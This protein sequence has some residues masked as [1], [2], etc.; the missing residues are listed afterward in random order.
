MIPIFRTWGAFSM[1]CFWLPLGRTEEKHRCQRDA[2]GTRRPF[3]VSLPAM[4]T[5]VIS[6][7]WLSSTFG[8]VVLTG[9]VDPDY[10]YK[11]ETIRPNLRLRK[12]TQVVGVITDV[13]GARF[14]Y[15]RVELREYVSQ[16]KQPTI[17]TVVT[18]ANGQFDL[19]LVKSGKYRLLPSPTR[20]FKQPEKLEC[21]SGDTCQLKI[22]LQANATDQPES[23]C[24]IR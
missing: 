22:A 24:P 21:Q 16:R 2:Q 20:A 8:Q 13:A 17:R 4:L 1:T 15:S 10:C 12:A 9:H 6:F 11:I 3:A 14:K 18:D 19:G 23:L 7:L 5:F